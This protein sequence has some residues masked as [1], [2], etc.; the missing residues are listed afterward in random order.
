M[1]HV[2]VSTLDLFLLT[3]ATLCIHSTAQW[4]VADSGD[5]L[6]S[7]LPLPDVIHNHVRLTPKHHARALKLKEELLGF[8]VGSLLV[9]SVLKRTSQPLKQFGLLWNAAFIMRAVCFASTTL[10]DA[11]QCCTVKVPCKLSRHGIETGSCHDLCFSGHVATTTLAAL[12]IAKHAPSLR[13]PATCVF[14]IQAF[15]TA[16]SKAHYTVDVVIALFLSC[17]LSANLYQQNNI[18][19]T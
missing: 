18:R 19:L 1:V 17:L 5:Q 13:I 9:L 2:D 16:A 3:T 10:P 12:T 8:A 11:S 4:Y 14:L 6:P 15:V 7:P